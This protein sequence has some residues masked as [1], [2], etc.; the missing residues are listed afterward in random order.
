MGKTQVQ[1]VDLLVT[2]R[3]NFKCV[4]CFHQQLP[5]DMG[6]GTLENALKCFSPYFSEDCVFN[7]F[8]GETFLRFDFMKEAVKM[9]RAKLPKSKFHLSTNMFF[10]S[11]EIVAFAKEYITCGGFQ[12]SYDGIDQ[13]TL[14]G[15]SAVVRENIRKSTYEIGLNKVYT[16][17]TFTK[18]TISHLYDNFVDMY[19]LGIRS[20]MHSADYCLGWTKEHLVEYALQLDKIYKFC[21][22]HPDYKVKF[23]D[24]NLATQSRE[25]TSCSMGKELVTVSA[26]G[27]I[28]PCHRAAAHPELNIGNVNENRFNRG[29]FLKIKCDKCD[30]CEA[31]QSCHNCS[32]AA[33]KHTGTLKTPLECVCAINK[34]EFHKAASVYKERY[35]VDPVNDG[36]FCDDILL[37]SYP[38][39][40][41]IKTDNQVFLKTIGV[42]DAS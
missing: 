10:Y 33:Y 8:G 20:A 22:Q 24:C 15:H 27:T 19:E 26:D 5:K 38:I 41:N 18:D 3:C 37:K 6:L 11:D 42:T 12:I 34:I 30:S 31:K 23:A 2:E 29:L 16:R 40:E 21:E 4:Y 1:W 25:K 17:L 7:F 28:Y 9:I 13:E 32:V 14:R 35:G 36:D 39:L